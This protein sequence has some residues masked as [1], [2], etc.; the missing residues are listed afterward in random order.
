MQAD[1]RRGS[2]PCTSNPLLTRGEGQEQRGQTRRGGPSSRRSTS[3]DPVRDVRRQLLDLGLVVPLDVPDRTR[4]PGGHE[5]DRCALA[6]EA[7]AAAD[8]V[9]VVL[10]ALRD[11]VVDHQRHL[12]HVDASREEVRGD[13]DPRGAGAELPHHQLALL[14]IQAGVHHGDREVPPPQ[15][16]SQLVG[17]ALRVAVDDA[18]GNGE[19]LVEV[20]EHVQLPLVPLQRHVE[21][22]DAL[23]RQL[24]PLHQDAHRLAHE[25]LRQLK[26]VPRHR[27]REE[28]DLHLRGQQFED[29]VDLVLKANGEHLVRLVEDEGAELC[30]PE[31]SAPDH[32]EDAPRGAH[33][34][35]LARAERLHVGAPRRAADAG[36]AL[37]PEVV[38]QRVR[39]LL[40]LQRQLARGRHHQRLARPA[41]EVDAR[42]GPDHEG[43]RL[44]RAG[45]GLPDDVAAPEHRLD[46]PRLDGA[47]PL[48]A[49][50]VDAA[51]EVVWQAHVIEGLVHRILVG[52]R[53]RDGGLLA[54]QR[55]RWPGSG[56]GRRWQRAL[57]VKVMVLRGA[58]APLLLAQLKLKP[59]A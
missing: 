30:H 14:L 22:V 37:R 18:L 43:G 23:E 44:P 16:L 17:P 58:T 19:R 57:G 2:A 24:V 27:R 20:D 48:E 52:A 34:H 8:A 51:E 38:A 45:L 36:V 56:C 25:L 32:V 49:E 9:Q 47:G 50:G 31:G 40:D 41:V 13:E 53:W 7:A 4:V 21:L 28:A 46:R 10:D 26:D 39:H 1:A 12:L 42:Q 15:L 55:H 59:N 11:V 35:V 29:L 6:A 3:S 5:V 54:A 33:D